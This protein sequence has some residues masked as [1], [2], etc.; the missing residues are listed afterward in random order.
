[1]AG[2]L[3]GISNA[4]QNDNNG[5]PLA[6]CLL[7]IFAGG[8][9]TPSLVYQD[10]GLVLPA[11]NPLVGDLSGRIPPFYLADGIYHVR[12]TDQFGQMSNGGF[13]IPQIPSIGASTSGGG[14]S[15][16]DPTTIAATG[17]LKWRLEDTTISG[18]VRI[19]GRTIGSSS[20]G[21]SERANADTQ[22]LFIYI[23]NTYADTI[24]P[25]L[26]GRGAS[27]LADFNANKQ[28]TLLDGR[29]RSIF[30]LDTM[31][32]SALG[33][34][35]G[36]TFT[37][38]NAATGGASG[39]TNALTLLTT[40]LPPYTPS[41]NI[42]GSIVAEGATSTAFQG[43]GGSYQVVVPNGSGTTSNNNPGLTAIIDTLAPDMNAQGGSSAPIASVPSA[44]LGT[45]F[46][47]L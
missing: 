38:G 42:N 6:N 32:N 4:Q 41:G 22:A 1:M 34:M 11:P 35:V 16:V 43:T 19:N 23:W 20:S 12:L 36:V 31:G 17:D 14:G 29:D 5:R 3:I 39:G 26:G 24:C 45:L 44:L 27:G 8:T 10:I 28:I 13:D 15:A 40:N 7:T 9:T 25:V 37:K 21:A 47:K 33:G 18:W 30:G 2:T 46:W